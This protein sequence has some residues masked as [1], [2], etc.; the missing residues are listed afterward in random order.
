MRTALV[1]GDTVVD[2]IIAG[3][4]YRAPR[5]VIAI[6]SETAGVGYK[7]DGKT[8]DRPQ[9]TK[10]ELLAHA[11]MRSNDIGNIVVDVPAV[12][13]K[14]P[15]R[16]SLTNMDQI[17]VGKIATRAEKNPDFQTPFQQTS[18]TSP[19]LML[20][21]KQYIALNDAIAEYYVKHHLAYAGV[22][23]A[24]KDGFVTGHDQIDNPPPH[25]RSWPLRRKD[26]PEFNYSI[27]SRG[28]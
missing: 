24:I 21:G 19:T 11:E 12:D 13:G 5:E 25:V 2:V 7:W 16:V 15:F 26:V 3:P 10:E 18:A 17:A 1:K 8:F 4:D 9:V 23:K 22:V 6:P 28:V 20:T 27:T 14:S